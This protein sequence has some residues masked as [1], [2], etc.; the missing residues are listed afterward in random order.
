MQILLSEEINKS[1]LSQ[2][3]SRNMYQANRA[4]Q[5]IELREFLSRVMEEMKITERSVD[6][7]VIGFNSYKICW[8]VGLVDFFE[9]RYLQKNDCL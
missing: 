8:F 2:V 5:I 3:H 4:Y 7:L 9:F 6:G 1:A